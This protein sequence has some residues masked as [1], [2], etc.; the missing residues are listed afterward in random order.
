[1]LEE[2]VRK[3]LINWNA[4]PLFDFKANVVETLKLMKANTKY[5]RDLKHL[6]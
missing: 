2:N 3:W 6:I 4:K 1:M 5:A